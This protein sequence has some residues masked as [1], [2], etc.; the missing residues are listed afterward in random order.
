M[1]WVMVWDL[2]G[3]EG[4]SYKCLV[5]NCLLDQAETMGHRV[6]FDL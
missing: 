1:L 2:K 6:D 5:N 4:N 3:E